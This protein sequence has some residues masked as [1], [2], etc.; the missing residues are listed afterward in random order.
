M[1]R[2][3]V[4]SLIL[5]FIIN[6]SHTEAQA[7][8]TISPTVAITVDSVVGPEFE[9][10]V[11]FSEPVTGFVQSGLTFAGS[12]TFTIT[13]WDAQ[14][15]GMVYVATVTA[16]SNSFFTSANVAANVA[17]DTAMNWN[18]EGSSSPFWVD[19]D[20]PTV[21]FNLPSGTPSGTFDVTIR[22]SEN[23]T[24]FV[25]SDIAVHN[26]TLD[27]LT[28]S[29]RVYMATITPTASGDVVFGID[30][31]QVKD[32]V[33]NGNAVSVATVTVDLVAP[34]VMFSDVPPGRQNGNF[35][36]TITFS[37]N[38]TGF[39]STT[40]DIVLSPN[41]LAT[42]SSLTGADMT[43]TA[44][45]APTAG[46]EGTLT[47]TVPANAAVDGATNGNDVASTTVDIDAKPPTLTIT[48]PS[49]TQTAA[50]DVT[51][52]FSEA[53]NGFTSGDIT[54]TAGARVSSFTTNSGTSY[55]AMITPKTTSTVTIRC[56][57]G[58]RDKILL[59]M[60]TKLHRSR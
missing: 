21:T 51:F 6:W 47:I 26:G 35:T 18:T 48:P 4:F 34:T 60:A 25:R 19:V 16:T 9:V 59:E 33:G 46:Q 36:I 50:F 7:Q 30:A 42:V 41:T 5:F 52:A 3:F 29:G 54:P 8:D 12:G 31:D 32:A 1:K 10:T 53:V 22:F 55:T 40:D 13:D 44:T 38:V 20:G 28:G 11:T 27:A 37:E 43:Y 49:G 2:F 14:A 58:C 39:T 15:G 17:Q 56:G 45:I 23:V 24:D 57:S